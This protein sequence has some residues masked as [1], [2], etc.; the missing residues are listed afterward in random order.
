MVTHIYNP[1]IWEKQES[2]VFKARLNYIVDL[3]IVWAT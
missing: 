2:Q 3:R 1:S